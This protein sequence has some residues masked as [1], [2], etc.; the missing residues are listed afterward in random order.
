MKPVIRYVCII[1]GLCFAGCQKS[2]QQD[3]LL[4][5]SFEEGV[6]LK[7]RMQ[8]ER[9]IRLELSS[10]GTIQKTQSK[11]AVESLELIMIYTPVEVDPF[12]L[13][14]IEVVCESAT[15]RR[16]G[17]SGTQTARDIMETLAGKSFILKLTPTGQIADASDL[18][19]VAKE[20]GN[21]SFS[22]SR[23]GKRIKD[24][25]MIS[26]FLAMQQFLW[27]AGA[28]ISNQLDLQVQDTWQ[29]QQIIAWPTPRYPPPSRTTTYTLDEIIEEPEQPRKAHITST[30][31]M[32]KT[33]I[34]TYVRPYEEGR[35]QTRGIFGFLR[36]YRFKQI[37]G[38][39][40]QIF[41]M[42]DGLVESDQQKYQL[43]VEA[44]FML[45]LGDSV[46]LLT[47]DQKFLIERIEQTP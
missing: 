41:N 4:L 34:E 17:F 36:N 40:S 37:D 11:T 9:S 6:P 21:A 26:D 38:A 47:V 12:G 35:F 24:P 22:S 13:S 3:N 18:E 2:A 32:S 14:T 42:D 8:S 19:R 39:G 29:A 15:V 20:L 31:T 45:P 27:D 43:H 44:G 1:I 30:Y 10:G 28:T 25:D 33:P 46:P 5:V 23:Q 7:Y 16:T